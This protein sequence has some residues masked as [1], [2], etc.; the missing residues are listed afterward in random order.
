MRK[1]KILL[2]IVLFL[3]LSSFVVSC[4]NNEEHSH[5]FSNWSII[6]ESTCADK[7]LKVHQCNG[8]GI[9]EYDTID[10]L[11]HN[12]NQ[13]IPCAK[14]LNSEATET[15]KAVYYISC[16]WGEKGIQTLE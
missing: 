12:F 11:N 16:T 8:C 1:I 7:G 6:I 13:E 3:S 4:S 9:V 15:N 14:Y 2:T 10:K 5:E